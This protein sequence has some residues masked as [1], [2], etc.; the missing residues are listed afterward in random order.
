MQS[1]SCF[2]LVALLACAWTGLASAETP[3]PQLPLEHDALQSVIEMKLDIAFE[4][5]TAAVEVAF[6]PNL[7]GP[8]SMNC[9]NGM[10]LETCVVTVAGT[11]RPPMSAMPAS[12]ASY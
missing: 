7:A 11:P 1:K 6:L 9:T 3:E 4:K 2:I 5:S 12:L 8:T 10:R